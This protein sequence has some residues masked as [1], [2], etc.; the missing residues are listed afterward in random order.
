M[1]RELKQLAVLLVLSAILVSAAGV[2]DCVLKIRM[3]EPQGWRQYVS[4]D[5]ISV[6]FAVAN[7]SNN[8]LLTS[9]NFTL[10]SNFNITLG[11]ATAFNPTPSP[12]P[13]YQYY[14]V[15]FTDSEEGAKNYIIYA[16]RSG[17]LNAT[18]AMYYYLTKKSMLEPNLPEY[19]LLLVPLAALLTMMLMRKKGKA[20]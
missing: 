14:V 18:K 7:L 9:G 4:G 6:R 19:D 10:L 20:I 5:I 8:S 17:C 12:G 15:N 11:N 1:G 13:A 3:V 16:S 2:G